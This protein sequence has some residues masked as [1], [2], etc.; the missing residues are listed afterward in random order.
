MTEAAHVE[1][2]AVTKRARDGRLCVDIAIDDLSEHTFW[3]NLALEVE[4]GG[5]FVATYRPVSIGTL[6]DLRLSL[7]DHDEPFTLSGVVRWT[8]PHIEGSDGVAGVGVKFVDL[9][10]DARDTITQFANAVREPMIF[11]LDDA[12]F[13]K[14][15]RSAA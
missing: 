8:R 6:V 5:V 3:A 7:P 12:P 11:E 15:R 14:R 9:T 2:P 10:E 13:R 1:Q 4:Q